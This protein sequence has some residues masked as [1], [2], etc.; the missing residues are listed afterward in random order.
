MP[1]RSS[2]G[3][4]WAGIV[5]PGRDKADLHPG[6]DLPCQ[7]FLSCNTEL[8]QWPSGPEGGEQKCFSMA[9]DVHVS[10]K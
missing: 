7:P 3:V 2:A 5:L 8:P 6:E 1:I 4:N 10:G 9:M